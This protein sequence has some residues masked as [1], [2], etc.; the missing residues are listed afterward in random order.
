MQGKNKYSYYL[1]ALM[2][3]GQSIWPAPNR[4]KRSRVFPLGTP[5]VRTNA[6]K[7]L[8]LRIFCS[9]ER[10]VIYQLAPKSAGASWVS[11]ALDF[12]CGDDIQSR[13]TPFYPL[14]LRDNL[15]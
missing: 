3:R 2:P 7:K 13:A 5:Y 4:R 6:D 11:S 8:A 14:T 15:I 12:V 10:A 1:Y 9:A